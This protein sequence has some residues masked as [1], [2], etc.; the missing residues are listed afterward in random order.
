MDPLSDASHCF[1]DANGEGHQFAVGQICSRETKASY[2]APQLGWSNTFH[3]LFHSLVFDLL[4]WVLPPM[5]L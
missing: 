1:I 4:V 5:I 2:N 3:F